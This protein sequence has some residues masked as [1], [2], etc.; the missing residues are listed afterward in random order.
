MDENEVA[1][2]LHYEAGGDAP[3]VT[4]SGR[5]A[6]ARQMLEVANQHGVAVRQDRTLAELLA[7]L[8]IGSV[9]PV[10]AFAAVAE[11]LAQLY[12][13]DRSMS[14]TERR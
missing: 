3:R 14:A 6:I 4:A 12:R 7:P 8:E 5:G 13:I 10:A 1:I 2:A 9:I 11:I